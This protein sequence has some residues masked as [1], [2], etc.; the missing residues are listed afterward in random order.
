MAAANLGTLGTAPLLLRE[1]LLFPY[2]GGLA[3]VA[4]VRKTQP[5]KAVD[6]V[7]KKPPL[8]TEH[9]LHPASYDRYE[10][11]DTITA[12]PPAALPGWTIAYQNVSGELGLGIFLRQHGVPSTTSAAGAQG[13]GKAELAG[14]GWGGGGLAGVVA[15]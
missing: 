2:V 7:Y 14:S 3:F 12:T 1:G 5:W 10:R 13:P 15:A 6:A 11:P 9:I 4:H 8:S